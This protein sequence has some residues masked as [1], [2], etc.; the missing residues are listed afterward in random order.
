MRP[1]TAL[2]LTLTAAAAS[3]PL[4]AQGVARMDARST[5]GRMVTIPAGRYVPLY[6][7][8]GAGAVSVASFRLD[9]V[10]VTRA[11]FAAFVAEQPAWQRSQVKRVYADRGYLANWASDLDAGDALATAGPVTGV[12]WFAAN[13]YCEWRGARLPT[14][15][16]WEFAAAASTR[17]RDAARDAGFMR[18]LMAAYTAPRGQ[19]LP[20]VGGGEPN[21]Y[22]VRD[23]HGLVWELVY[24]FNGVMVSDDSRA[25]GSGRERDHQAYCAG[26]AIGATD[27]DNYPAFLRHAVRAGLSGRTTLDGLGFRC[28]AD[29]PAGG[30]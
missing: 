28:A 25:S 6:S 27:P 7:R 10:P 15:T 12:S 26:A 1:F 18:H 14:M 13:A 2:F 8:A 11:E 22:G 16:E 21:V 3:L 23:L 4:A 5:N 24:D 19:V 9:T 29:A 20:P 30:H 17:E